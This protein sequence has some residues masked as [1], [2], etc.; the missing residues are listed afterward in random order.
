MMRLAMI[1]DDDDD[2]EVKGVVMVSCD[3]LWWC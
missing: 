1:D 2:G 3:K